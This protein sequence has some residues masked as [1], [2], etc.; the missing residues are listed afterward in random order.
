MRFLIICAS[1]FIGSNVLAYVR[2][3]GF[4]VIGTQSHSRDPEFV[5]FNLLNDRIVDCVGKSFFEKEGQVSVIICAVVS[6]MDQCLLD[7]QTSHRINVEQTIQLIED[8]RAFKAKVVFPSTCFV[9]DGTRGYY[10]E[11]HPVTPVNEY[12]RQKVEVETFLEK[13]LPDAFVARLEKIIS[14][15]PNDGQFFAQWIKLLEAGKPIVCIQGSLL[16]PTYVKDVAHAFVLACQKNLT[17][18]YHVS[19]SEFFYRDELARQFCY[20]MG[21]PPNV[22]SRPLEEFKFPDKRALKCYLDGSKFALES[23]MKF[24]AMREVFQNFRKKLDKNP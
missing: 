8:V 13:R 22:V 24:T 11:E 4:E 23:G 14:D 16:S 9:F 18:V 3:L 2:S 5:R 19:N 10:S 1:G 7:R 17:G 15:S 6:N 20:A 21:Q 12:A